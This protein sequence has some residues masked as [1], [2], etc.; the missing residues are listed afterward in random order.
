[1]V[2]LTNPEL[3]SAMQNSYVLQQHLST[4]EINI[5]IEKAFELGQKEQKKL[6]KKFTEEKIDIKL[7]TLK[8]K[9]E[10]REKLKKYQLDITKIIT[11]FKKI[12]KKQAEQKSEKQNKTDITTLE[13]TLKDL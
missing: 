6:L 2:I 12:T 3:M 11:D 1:M 4:H 9:D 13:N 5:L 10:N 8:N 7:H